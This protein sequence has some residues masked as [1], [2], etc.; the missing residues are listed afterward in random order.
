MLLAKKPQEACQKDGSASWTI[1]FTLLRHD[2]KSSFVAV[3][4]CVMI[5]ETK[6]Q[7]SRHMDFGLILDYLFYFDYS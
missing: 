2:D 7:E 3:V 4:L 6:P 5:L 1:F